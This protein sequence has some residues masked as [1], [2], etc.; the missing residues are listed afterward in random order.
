MVRFKKSKA[1]RTVLLSENVKYLAENT[2]FNKD[3]IMEWHQ[4]RLYTILV[5][6]PSLFSGHFNEAIRGSD[7]FDIKLMMATL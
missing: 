4:V 7:T 3:N 2:Q 6:P 1:T 5:K